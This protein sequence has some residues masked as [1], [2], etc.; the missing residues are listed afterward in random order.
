MDL[1]RLHQ[2]FY[3]GQFRR[4]RQ[5][6]D[7]LVI[8]L[9][10]EKRD[11][12]GDRLL[13]EQAWVE[14]IVGNRDRSRE[15]LALPVDVNTT[16]LEQVIGT[17]YTLTL[18]GEPEEAESLLKDAVELYPD[19]TLL[20]NVHTPT[21]RA[22][23]ESQGGELES[24]LRQLRPVARYE[25]APQA[26]KYK[27]IRG[28]ILLELKRGDEAVEAFQKIEDHPGQITYFFRDP[29]VSSWIEIPV[30]QVGLARAKAISGDIAGARKAYEKFFEM[31]KDAD[32]DI[33]LLVEA[34][35]EY[36]KLATGN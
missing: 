28:Q 1:F 26:D 5:I 17:A 2:A 15:Y 11:E 30:A 36:E 31:W 33:P 18:L 16:H 34:K 6:L 12:L 14:A 23:M 19:A 10:Q 24:A 35:A 29:P 27:L 13:R 9:N 20:K 21:I 7:D 32:E 25:K 8:F 4:G 22:M 3:H